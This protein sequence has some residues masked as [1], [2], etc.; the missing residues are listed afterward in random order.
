MVGYPLE[1]GRE[2]D[3]HPLAGEPGRGIEALQLGP[4]RGAHP[5]LLLELALGAFELGLALDV[6]LA[7]RQLEQGRLADRLARLAHQVDVALVVGDDRNGAG[8]DDDLAL[9]GLAVGVAK[10]LD[11][12][13]DDP[14]LVDASSSGSAPSPLPYPSTAAASARPA[15]S[16]AAKNSG[17]SAIVRPIVLRRQPAFRVAVEVDRLD[18][19]V[20]ATGAER[21]QLV[22]RRPCRATRRSL[23]VASRGQPSSSASGTG[24]RTGASNSSSTDAV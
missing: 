13:V 10:L 8:M 16:G 2:E 21:D 19:E 22:E 1:I 24:T 12:D 9:R 3:R 6:E 17:S 11:L 20:V 7:G 5:D 18:G 23:L 15:A 4:L 14:A